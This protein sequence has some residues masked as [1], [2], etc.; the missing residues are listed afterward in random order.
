[1][2]KTAL[3][4]V[5]MCQ[6]SKQMLTTKLWFYVDLSTYFY[7]F[8]NSIRRSKLN[9]ESNGGLLHVYIVKLKRL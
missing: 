6:E 2:E 9:L 5:R 7:S 1:M 4:L 8:N 3:D